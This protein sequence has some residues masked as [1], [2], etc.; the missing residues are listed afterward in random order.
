MRNHATV[1]RPTWHRQ[2]HAEG[3]RIARS[4]VRR[5][6][7]NARRRST[8]SG[9]GK[10][11]RFAARPLRTRCFP[12]RSCPGEGSPTRAGKV[13]LVVVEPPAA[14]IAKDNLTGMPTTRRKWMY[15]LSAATP[16]AVDVFV[17]EPL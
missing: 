8:L 12:L 1:G 6:L 10:E 16:A 7:G 9:A 17:V 14:G 3:F 11:N 2:S 13:Q 15:G 5:G 4:E